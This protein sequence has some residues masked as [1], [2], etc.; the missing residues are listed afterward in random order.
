MLRLLIATHNTG[1][2]RELSDLLGDLPIEWVTPEE[3]GLHLQ[4]IED[5]NTYEENAAKKAV[6]H[7][8]ASG[9][10]SLADDSGL[11]VEALGGAPGLHSARYLPGVD[12]TDADRR[13]YLLKNLEG[14]PRPWKACFRAAV[15]IAVPHEGVRNA[16]GACVG[17]IIPEERGTGGF[18]YDPIFLVEKTGRTMAELPMAEKNRVSHR[19]RA[20]MKAAA[21]LTDLLQS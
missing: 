14:K 7:A 10:V 6:A 15:A 16:E 18:G 8:E 3:I 13:A 21:I 11:E 19:A 12:A 4:I 20:M 1:K 9:L 2:R 5:G 17:E